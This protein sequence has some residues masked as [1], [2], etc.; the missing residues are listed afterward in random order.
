MRRENLSDQIVKSSMDFSE[1]TKHEKEFR[2]FFIGL[3]GFYHC[4]YQKCE[5][6]VEQEWINTNDK[7]R[8]IPKELYRKLRNDRKGKFFRKFISDKKRQEDYKFSGMLDTYIDWD[9]ERGTSDYD[10]EKNTIDRTV[11]AFVKFLSKDLTTYYKQ[12]S[13]NE[14]LSFDEFMKMNYK[15]DEKR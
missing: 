14:I 7:F 10:N 4:S 8:K 1:K 2:N 13:K 9:Y 3:N 5:N 11:T 6:T 12:G 15:N